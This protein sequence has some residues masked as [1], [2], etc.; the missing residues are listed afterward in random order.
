MSKFHGTFS[1]N[2][3][4]RAANLGKI[5]NKYDIVAL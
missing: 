3:V 1:S 2:A 5:L 4:V